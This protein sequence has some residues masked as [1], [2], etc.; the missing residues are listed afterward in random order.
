M[1]E[2]A[3]R[4]DNCEGVRHYHHVRQRRHVGQTFLLKAAASAVSA[5]QDLACL[6]GGMIAAAPRAAMV[7]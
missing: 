4:L 1:K 5:F 6:R 2:I 3:G 7:S